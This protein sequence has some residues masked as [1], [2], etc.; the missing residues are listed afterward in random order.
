MLD[1]SSYCHR[2]TVTVVPDGVAQELEA[3]GGGWSLSDTAVVFG[4]I[5]IDL[6]VGGASANVS[7]RKEVT[8]MPKNAAAAAP[9]SGREEKA[10]GHGD[11][12]AGLACAQRP[13]G[14]SG[15][16][17]PR[18]SDA[19]TA[20]FQRASVPITLVLLLGA[21]TVLCMAVWAA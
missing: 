12:S 14:E 20:E 9:A 2:H 5:A 4:L 17:T 10:C 6:R 8:T 7:M 21:S 1:T 18:S 15:T 3:S 19:C 11:G 13:S 16:P